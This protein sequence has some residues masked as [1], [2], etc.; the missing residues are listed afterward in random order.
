MREHKLNGQTAR[1]Q[2][3]T[4]RFESLPKSH[5]KLLRNGR[6]VRLAHA[7]VGNVRESRAAT[8]N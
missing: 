7:L 8:A 5:S 3:E 1:L 2:N 6:R 4:S